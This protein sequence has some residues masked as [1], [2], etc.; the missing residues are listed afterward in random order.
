MKSKKLL[1][2]SFLMLGGLIAYLGLS[3][4]SSGVM[5]ASTS[6]CSCH[7][8]ASTA[9][10]ITLTGIPSTGYV[11][12]TPYT[13]TLSV[14]NSTKKGA[15]FDLTCDNG[16]MSGAPSGTMLMGGGKELH[17][18]A[19]KDTVAG[20]VSWTFT[21]TAPGTSTATFKVAGNAVN[22]NIGD[23]GDA[24]ALGTFDFILQPA[25][26]QDI[27]AAGIRV[28]P[29]PVSDFLVVSSNESLDISK[30]KIVTLTGSVINPSVNISAKNEY[31]ISTANI[32][33][34]HYILS[35][36]VDGKIFARHFVKQ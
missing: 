31:K 11:A 23:S 20:V 9:T 12:G 21:W 28:Y 25:S 2:S 7:G 33:T 14:I 26:V 8:A 1:L 17:H 3:S 24:W 29:N 18:T 16:N 5:G 19:T 32:A 34:G 6:G 10:T 27:E 35:T 13:V 22:K 4:S 15:G 30:I 36:E